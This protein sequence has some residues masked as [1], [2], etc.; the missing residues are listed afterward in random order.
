MN[1]RV[2]S[3]EKASHF[4]VD[5]ILNIAKRLSGRRA[6]QVTLSYSKFNDLTV[7][8]LIK[9]GAPPMSAPAWEKS[10]FE[11]HGFCLDA[12]TY[13]PRK[14]SPGMNI[15]IVIN[16][17]SEFQMFAELENFLLDTVRHEIEHI[18]QVDRRNPELRKAH[19]S[20]YRYFL[21]ADEIPA[22]VA[23]LKMLA[24]RQS[25]DLETAI[26]NYLEPFQK[27]GFMTDSESAE[28]KS[29]WLSHASAN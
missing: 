23:G 3:A 10:N 19:Q 28:V 14:G 29:A 21:L 16:P 8:L 2:E 15:E 7:H 22:A 9:R 4:I 25:I 17:L 26:D 11:K 12:N 18:Q 6:I 27:S 24:K 1:S 13:V 5:D 20:S